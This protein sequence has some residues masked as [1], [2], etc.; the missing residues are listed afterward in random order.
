[1]SGRISEKV[2]HQIQ[3]RV[4]LVE[5]IGQDVKLRRTGNNWVGLCPFHSDGKPSFSV[6]PDK[7]FYYCFGCREGGNAVS[8]LMKQR[9]MSYVEALESLAS[10]T[11][12]ELE[13]EEGDRARWS[14]TRERRK[15]LQDLNREALSLFR[16]QLFASVGSRALQYLQE[17]GLDRETISTF[18]IGFAPSGSSY[19][20]RMVQTGAPLNMAEELGLIVRSRRDGAY[21]DKFG[22]RI[23]FPVLTV[24]DHIAGFSGRALPNGHDPKYLNSPE[25]EI[26]SKGNLLFG[27][28][29]AREQAKKQDVCLIVEGQIDVIA[30]HQAGFSNVVAP[31]GTALTEH[32]AGL[33]RRFTTNVILVFDGDDAG[34]KATW[35]AMT[36]LMNQGLYGKVAVM[37][38]G[39]DPDSVLRQQG[40]EALSGLIGRALPFLEYAV[41]VLLAAAGRD[42]HG[43]TVAARKG[44]EFAAE[45]RSPIDRQV[46]VERLAGELGLSPG[47]LRVEA[48]PHVNNRFE[49]PSGVQ[50]AVLEDISVRERELLEFVFRKPELVRVVCEDDVFELIESQAVRTFFLQLLDDFEESGRVDRNTALARTVEPAVKDILA[51]L[52]LEEDIMPEPAIERAVVDLVKS[53]RRT[54][55]R[56]RREAVQ[57]DVKRAEARGDLDEALALSRKIDKLER[58]MAALA[59]FRH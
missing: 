32:Q 52:L 20:K 44:M 18:Q 35:R 37:P 2:I 22:G 41:E 26:F 31:L 3:E 47:A 16:S 53:L 1:M 48:S 15:T 59:G 4:N 6:N 30:M 42:L 25:S 17:R 33:L 23:V 19:Y 54:G 51:R 36:I 56:K 55:I 46:F 9:G 5:I 45:I 34:R 24:G 29:Q 43:R 27:L 39:S 10:Q 14:Q 11:G 57:L 28:V 12:I 21:Y 50:M 7:G 38:V 13:F 58:E 49:D 40:K 8:Y